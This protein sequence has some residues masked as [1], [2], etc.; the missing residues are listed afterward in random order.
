[1][2]EKELCVGDGCAMCSG[3]VYSVQLCTV[4]AVRICACGV[5]VLCCGAGRV[6]VY[7]ACSLASIRTIVTAVASSFAFLLFCFFPNYTRGESRRI[8]SFPIARVA[9]FVLSGRR[10]GARSKQSRCCKVSRSESSARA[11]GAEGARRSPGRA[12]RE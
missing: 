11:E 1:M 7:V 6:C 5:A 8:I 12:W 4:G 10:G 2:G 9:S 3:D